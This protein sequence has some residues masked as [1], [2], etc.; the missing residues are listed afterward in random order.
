[1]RRL[2]LKHSSS[3]NDGYACN[4]LFEACHYCAYSGHRADISALRSIVYG[5]TLSTT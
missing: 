2:F 1:M 4:R 5:I 3:W